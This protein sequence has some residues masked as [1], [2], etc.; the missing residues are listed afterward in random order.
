[1]SSKNGER[2]LSREGDGSPLSLL[3]LLPTEACGCLIGVEEA[4]ANE[5][6]FLS[7]P[8]TAGGVLTAKAIEVS[9][10]LSCRRVV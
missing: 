5:A 4:T 9:A 10:V 2:A 3:R 7:G 1:M 8:G 6:S